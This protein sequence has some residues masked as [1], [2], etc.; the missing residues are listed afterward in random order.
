MHFHTNPV[1]PVAKRRMADARRI[2]LALGKKLCVCG[3]IG[4]YLVAGVHY[5]QAHKNEAEEQNQFPTTAQ[6]AFPTNSNTGDPKCPYRVGT[7]AHK[8]W[9]EEIRDRMRRFPTEAERRLRDALEADERTAGKWEFQPICFGFIPDFVCES[10][11]MI[12][13]VD[14]EVHFT[15][16][17][18]RADARRDNIFNLKGFHV[19]RFTN[20]QVIY[21]TSKVTRKI[22]ELQCAR[23]DGKGLRSARILTGHLT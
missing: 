20:R 13:E 4:D 9:K 12:V 22:A 19:L 6:S 16:A 14:G 18:K 1:N 11:R 5:C 15:T 10:A 8:E 3:R 7:I 23:L 21:H 17:A 2:A